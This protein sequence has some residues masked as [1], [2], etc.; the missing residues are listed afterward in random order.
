MGNYKAESTLLPTSYT[1]IQQ[2][3]S[4]SLFLK[5]IIGLSSE[6]T[7]L[8]EFKNFNFSMVPLS[9]KINKNTYE[10]LKKSTCFKAG[11]IVGWTMRKNVALWGRGRVGDGAVP[12]SVSRT[13]RVW[14][15]QTGD[16]R[17]F[18]WFLAF[19]SGKRKLFSI[20]T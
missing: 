16:G 11:P 4:H 19:Y 15:G 6:S 14:L 20:D 17:S 2:W 3:V 8:E 12:E 13:G 5:I 9:E 1:T 18:S 10:I 7:F